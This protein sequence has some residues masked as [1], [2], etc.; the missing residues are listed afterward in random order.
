MVEAAIQSAAQGRRV[1]IDD[2]LER[3]YDAALVAERNPEVLG[4]LKSWPSVRD[5]LNR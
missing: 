5:A 1:V 2:V 3:S 4:V